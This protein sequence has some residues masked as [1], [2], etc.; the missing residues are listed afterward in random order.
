M[1]IGISGC[2]FFFIIRIVLRSSPTIAIQQIFVE[3]W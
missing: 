1:S 3:D 2:F